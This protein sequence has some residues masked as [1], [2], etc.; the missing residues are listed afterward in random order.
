MSEEPVTTF[1]IDKT[2]PCIT[3]LKYAVCVTK[4]ELKCEDLVMWLT[5][6]TTGSEEFSNRLVGFEAWWGREASVITQD[7]LKMYFKK[8]K[9]TYQCLFVKNM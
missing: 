7:S 6:L 2:L 8:K 5:E 9:D 4:D 1:K 3:C